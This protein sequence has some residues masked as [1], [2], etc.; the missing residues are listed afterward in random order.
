MKTVCL[1][2][3]LALGCSST[4]DAADD[5]DVETGGSQFEATGGSEA[6]GG[7]P[8]APATG[9][10]SSVVSETGGATLVA[11]GGRLA[12][13][14]RAATG[15]AS[16][17]GGSTCKP[18]L[19]S[20]LNGLVGASSLSNY[21]QMTGA[22]TWRGQDGCGGPLVCACSYDADAAGYVCQ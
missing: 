13:G 20:S 17:T 21:N 4:T 7:E 5:P 8:A 19:C 22:G 11:T 1:L 14:G 10:A 3:A 9:G 2:V 15:G 6:T 18:N 16:A 12:T